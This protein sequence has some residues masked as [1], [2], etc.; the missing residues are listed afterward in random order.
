MNGRNID[1][2]KVK[3]IIHVYN[4]TYAIFCKTISEVLF[5]K[6]F[7]LNRAWVSYYFPSLS[8]LNLKKFKILVQLTKFRL[9]CNFPLL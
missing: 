4:Y 1:E 8:A 3:E 2:K 6:I 7:H 9:I 5:L